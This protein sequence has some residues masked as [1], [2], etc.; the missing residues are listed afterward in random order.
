MCVE[1]CKAMRKVRGGE[2][3]YVSDAARGHHEK[4]V[5]GA[6]FVPRDIH[7]DYAFWTCFL[8][9]IVLVF[10]AFFVL[11]QYFEF[12]CLWECSMCCLTG[13]FSSCL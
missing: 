5:V 3:L 4:T 11:V 9:F 7:D 10:R 1:T 2:L 6:L 8:I 12:H 13:A